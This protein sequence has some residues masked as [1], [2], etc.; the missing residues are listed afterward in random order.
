VDIRVANTVSPN[1]SITMQRSSSL[2]QT[3]AINDNLYVQ[4]PVHSYLYMYS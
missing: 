3:G 4:K 2:A 1:T